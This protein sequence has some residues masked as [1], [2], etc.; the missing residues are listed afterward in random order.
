MVERSTE[1][2]KI[3]LKALLAGAVVIG[4]VVVAK[5]SCTQ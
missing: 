3:M 1:E 4:A 5:R 2:A